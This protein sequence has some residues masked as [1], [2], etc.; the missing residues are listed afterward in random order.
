MITVLLFGFGIQ[1]LRK[2]SPAH[3][4]KNADLSK[5]ITRVETKPR[6][7]SPPIANVEREV[8]IEPADR[9][10]AMCATMR[11]A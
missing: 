6:S 1:G 11:C 2:H 10:L 7:V 3:T 5:L 8:V 9:A 4:T